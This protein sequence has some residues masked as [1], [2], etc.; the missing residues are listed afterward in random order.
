MKKINWTDVY[1]KWNKLNSGLQQFLISVVIFITVI[2]G[3]GYLI[4]MGS[5]H[6]CF[7]PAILSGLVFG[8]GSLVAG[9]A[10]LIE[11]LE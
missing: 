3:C 4:F 7:I 5:E 9:S 2:W 1:K 11:W 8:F 10:G 6:W